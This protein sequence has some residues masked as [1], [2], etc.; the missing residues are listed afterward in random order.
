VIALPN[1]FAKSI[2]LADLNADH[3]LDMLV[4]SPGFSGG[5]MLVFLGNGD[6][7]FGSPTPFPAGANAG[8]TFT[9]GDLNGDSWVDVIVPNSG[10]PILYNET[11]EINV[12]PGRGDGTFGPSTHAL[13]EHSPTT[14]A[15]GDF[16]EDGRM[17]VATANF[18]P[19]SAS[20]LLRNANGTFG[21]DSRISVGQTP[22]G[23][24]LQDLNGDGYPDIETANRGSASVSVLLN[25][26]RGAF[27]SKRDYAVEAGPAALATGDLDGDSR[28]DL[29][30]PNY[31]VNSVTVLHGVGDGGLSRRVDLAAPP[32]PHAVTIADL[33]NDGPPD[34]TVGSANGTVGCIL[35]V[36]TARPGT[37][38]SGAVEQGAI[39]TILGSRNGAFSP[40]ST[41]TLGRYVSSVACGD[42]DGDR[43]LDLAVTARLYGY[44]GSEAVFVAR[45]LGN[46]AFGSTVEVASLRYVGAI[47]IEDLDG[48]GRLDLIV[49]R[50][51]PCGTGG[52]GITLLLNQAD[53]TFQETESFSTPGGAHAIAV[54]DLNGDG[55]ADIATANPSNT[56]SVFF[57]NGDGTLQPKLTFGTGTT[58][59]ALAIGDLNG[60]GRMDLAVANAWGN[61]VSILLNLRGAAA[62]AAHAFLTGG[63]RTIPI[64]AGPPRLCVR[65]E[66]AGGSF[67][68]AAVDPSTLWMISDGTGSVNRIPAVSA[69]GAIT[70]DSDGNGISELAACFERADLASLFQYVR[71]KRAI[72]VLIEGRLADG[73]TFHASLTMTVV[74]TGARLHA[75]VTPNPFL[76]AGAFSVATQTPGPIKVLV[77]DAGGRLVRVIVNI[78]VAPAGEHSFGFDDRRGDGTRLASG[79][80]FY[81]VETKA[82]I[83]TGKLVIAR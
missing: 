76:G 20:V 1:V 26:G 11:P 73:R 80:Y 14:A 32:F 34:I 78:P 50:S 72:P 16:N 13:T 75:A 70:G 79:I 63:E 46:G 3:H 25:S 54:G 60:D 53:G 22:T 47:A 77:F 49:G 64:G 28:I 69:K 45:G 36:P 83:Q 30:V 7:T 56:A 27:G 67:E 74:G 6:G 8:E 51:D 52:G 68:P 55:R 40:G 62:P 19:G 5:S 9:V 41:A 57:G 43:I 23:I 66:P 81:R 2:A 42:L 12:L 24:A 38:K 10:F 29:V 21:V 33:N 44:V 61:T 35:E 71:G 4:L 65:V 59:L 15:I 82:G 31:D 17:D 58:P 37:S 18:I 48:N 39:A